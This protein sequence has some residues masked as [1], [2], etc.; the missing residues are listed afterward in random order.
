MFTMCHGRTLNHMAA[1]VRSPGAPWVPWARA[2][3]SGAQPLRVLKANRDW[4]EGGAWPVGLTPVEADRIAAESDH[5][6][7]MRSLKFTFTL[8]T[9]KG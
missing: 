7:R 5:S 3:S 1:A 8:F 6:C 2:A 9:E 4:A